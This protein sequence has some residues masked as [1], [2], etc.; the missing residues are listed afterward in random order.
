MRGSSLFRLALLPFFPAVLLGV[1]VSAAPDAPH[2]AYLRKIAELSQLSVD[3]LRVAAQRPGTTL[4]E[5]NAVAMA[6][7]HH[8][9]TPED[10]TFFY[11]V[12]WRTNALFGREA[13]AML[14]AAYVNRCPKEWT[15]SEIQAF[16]RAAAWDLPME[17]IESE[18]ARLK[19]R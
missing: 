15:T 11:G 1:E 16:A 6:A 8:D 3:D 19:P 4:L 7:I 12:L 18:M 2:T 17:A 13:Q 5:Q 14:V 9:L 10:L